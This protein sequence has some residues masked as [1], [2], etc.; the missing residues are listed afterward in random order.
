MRPA[1]LS[2]T[3]FSRMNSNACAKVAGGESERFD[4]GLALGPPAP[5]NLARRKHRMPGMVI[6]PDGKIEDSHD[7][8][9]NGLVEKS[10][11]LPDGACAF[12]VESVEQS[13]NGIR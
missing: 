12:I 5:L 8:V 1:E 3:E 11:V 4:Q 6:T 2:E 10:I 9:S 13:R 7:G